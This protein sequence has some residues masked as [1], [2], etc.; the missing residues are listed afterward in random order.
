MNIIR[1]MDKVR[2][3]LE[4][5]PYYNEQLKKLGAKWSSIDQQWLLPLEQYQQALA[6][7]D[8]TLD[9]KLGS[10]DT[11]L[12]EVKED[13][14]RL[15]YSPKTIKTYLSNIGLF[16]KYSKGICTTESINRYL[17]YLLEEKHSSHS[18]CNQ[19][20]N[21]I[22]FYARKYGDITENEVLKL[23]R[24]KKEKKLPKVMDKTEV[25]ELLEVT[26]N[27]KHKTELMLAYSCGLR[28]SEVAA[29]KIRDIDSKRMVVMVKQGKGRKDR[30]ALLSKLMLEQL[31]EY[32]RSYKP[33]E[34]LF[35]NQTR[36]GP[37]S[38]RSL[39]NVFNTAARK[40][41]INK[42]VTFHSLRHSF[43]T[44]LLESGVDLRYIQELLGHSSSKTTEIY[45]HVSL[46]S[47]QKIANP[48]DT[49]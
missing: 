25:K 38:V 31:R 13:M 12:K 35:E 3:E 17:L 43:A 26:V 37:I 21:G 4:F 20:I 40:A 32:Y 16:L 5:N 7:F 27:L 39:Q 23:Q 8:R 1:G 10:V 29:M 11:R 14:V 47:I 49:L 15:G 41:G 42:P 2:I 9:G 6:I 19:A 18:Y 24:P 34:W 48:L 36:S 22:K 33:K 28:V 46:Q 45:T 44:H 30:Q